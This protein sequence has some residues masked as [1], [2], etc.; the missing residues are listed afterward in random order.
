MNGGRQ[1]MIY[2]NGIR[3]SRADLRALLQWIKAGK[4]TATA[5]TTKAGALAI[6]T[7]F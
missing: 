2:I 6:T 4:T 1:T 7:S 3:A 5:R